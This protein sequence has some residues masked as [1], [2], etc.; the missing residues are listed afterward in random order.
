MDYPVARFFK[1]WFKYFDDLEE[2]T[3]ALTEQQFEAY[4]ELLRL[5]FEATYQPY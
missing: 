4:R 3:G 2:V 5:D 1:F